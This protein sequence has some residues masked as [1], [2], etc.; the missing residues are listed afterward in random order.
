MSDPGGNFWSY[1]PDPEDDPGVVP[2]PVP[3]GEP[4]W[5]WEL[6]DAGVPIESFGL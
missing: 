3:S 4:Y 1:I 5:A 2:G 6:H